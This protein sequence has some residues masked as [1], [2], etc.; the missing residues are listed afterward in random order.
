[1]GKVRVLDR[2]VRQGRWPTLATSGVELR[3]LP[4]QQPHGPGIADDVVDG[5]E[6]C[7]LFLAQADEPTPEHRIRT[8]IEGARE[9]LPG[10]AAGLVL[11][12]AGRSPGQI[13]Q[14]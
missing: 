12:A 14:G 1:M 4:D 7:V 9:L 13:H 5:R 6:E 3:E 10:E 8:K 11:L 2:E